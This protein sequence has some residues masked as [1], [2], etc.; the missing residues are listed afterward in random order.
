MF[1][2]LI[3]NFERVAD[4]CSNIAVALLELQADAF[5]THAYL[6]DMRSRQNESF[7]RMLQEYSEEFEFLS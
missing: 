2:D 3:G 6:Q 1:N 5:D 4:H 7:Q